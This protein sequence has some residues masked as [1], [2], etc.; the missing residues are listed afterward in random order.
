MTFFA[1][2]ILKY[3]APPPSPNKKNVPSLIENN[4]LLKKNKEKDH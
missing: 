4:N 1:K 3:P 2:K